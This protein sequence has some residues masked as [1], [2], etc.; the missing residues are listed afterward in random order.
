MSTFLDV[1]RYASLRGV[2]IAQGLV[3][4]ATYLMYYGPTLIV[5]QF[6]FDIYTS[7][8]VLN[9]SDILVYYPLMVMID[10][11]QRRKSCIILFLIATVLS[12]ILIFLTKP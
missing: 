2:T 1:F 7:E 3:S 8:T 6:G 9:I 4:M 12:G 11:I 10:K 5:S